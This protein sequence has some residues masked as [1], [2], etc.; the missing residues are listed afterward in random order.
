M[1]AEGPLSWRW[2]RFFFVLF[3]WGLRDSFDRRHFGRTGR[4]EGMPGAGSSWAR[5]GVGNYEGCLVD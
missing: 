2:W 5:G 1:G 4:L 3:G